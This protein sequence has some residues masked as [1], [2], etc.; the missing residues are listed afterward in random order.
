MAELYRE[1]GYV[2]RYWSN[3]PDEP[4]HI[5]V[6]K[7]GNEAKFWLEPVRLYRNYGFT[8][9]QL[10][11]IRQIITEQHGLLVRGCIDEREKNS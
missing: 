5:H 6:R 7:A 10:R 4:L 8:A 11:K 3:E 2:F 1:A 9:A